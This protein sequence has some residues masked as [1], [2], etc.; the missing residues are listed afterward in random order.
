[1]VIFIIFLRRNETL[2]ISNISSRQ[3][4]LDSQAYQNPSPTETAL[5][6]EILIVLFMSHYSG[7]IIYFVVAQ[8]SNATVL[9][10]YFIVQRNT[11]YFTGVITVCAS[12]IFN[13]IYFLVVCCVEELN[14]NQIRQHC[15]IANNCSQYFL[16]NRTKRHLIA[17]YCTTMQCN[18][19]ILTEMVALVGCTIT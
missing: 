4:K 7:Q 17:F 3:V 15:R 5:Y 11:W 8:P 18:R 16:H 1:M 10:L 19:V 2:E 6:C 9:A 12:N 13:I 14:P